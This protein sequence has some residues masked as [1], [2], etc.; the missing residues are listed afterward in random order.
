MPIESISPWEGND[1]VEVS[2]SSLGQALLDHLGQEAFAELARYEHFPDRWDGYSAPAFQP[3]V[4][5]AARGIVRSALDYF[6]RLE[7]VPTEITPGPASD[8]SVDVEIAVGG[9]RVIFTIYPELE[10][11]EIYRSS[12]KGRRTFAEPFGEAALVR[13]LAWLQS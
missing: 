9:R 6:D 1:T 12:S 8:G 11:L 13:Q 4:I 7:I 5:R 3:S 10:R 2:R